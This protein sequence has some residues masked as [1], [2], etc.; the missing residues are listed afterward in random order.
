MIK[1]VQ[2][3]QSMEAITSSAEQIVNM[4]ISGACQKHNVLP[5]CELLIIW[6]KE[7]EALL[8]K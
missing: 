1:D 4:L 3:R 8:D 5:E 2:V 7:L 6:V